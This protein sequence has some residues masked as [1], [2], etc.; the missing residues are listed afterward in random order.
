M[1][2]NIYDGEGGSFEIA[3]ELWG[4]CD[5]AMQCRYKG[6]D[7]SYKLAHKNILGKISEFEDERENNVKI[8][9]S[10]EWFKYIIKIYVLNSNNISEKV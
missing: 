3:K 7:G 8:E 9:N 10:E 1:I 4:V 6:E 5:F 2:D